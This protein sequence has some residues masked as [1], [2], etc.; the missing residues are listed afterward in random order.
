MKSQLIITS[1]G[2]HT[3]FVPDLKEHY[4]SI[5]GA[6]TESRHVFINTGLK[7]CMQ[8]NLNILEVGFGTGLNALLTFIESDEAGLQINYVCYE[9]FPLLPHI[10]RNLNYPD[11]L[12]HPL[13]GKVFLE[14]HASGWNST[15]IMSKHFQFCKIH[16]KIEFASLP[17]NYFQL[18]YFDAFAPSVQPE[19]WSEQ[20]FRKLYDASQTNGILVTYSAMGEVRRNM[21]KAGYRVQRLPG[22]PG[23]REMLRATKSSLI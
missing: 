6:I 22:A 15:I 14:M 2:S 20:I 19:L 7:S 12:T 10:Y 4:H 21:I 3:L 8:A 17:G 16:E 9:P 18:I 5:F 13:A 23:K 1:D 11:L